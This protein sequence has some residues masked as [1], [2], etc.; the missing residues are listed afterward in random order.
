MRQDGVWRAAI[1]SNDAGQ[2]AISVE[3]AWQAATSFEDA[4]SVAAPSSSRVFSSA[5]LTEER[6]VAI[7]TK[8]GLALGTIGGLAIAAGVLAYATPLS[9]L[10][11]GGTA[12]LVSPCT[13]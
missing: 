2:A 4:R 7:F 5:K 8:V 1:S 6:Y 3:A 12:P 10:Y 11:C 13:R 9:T